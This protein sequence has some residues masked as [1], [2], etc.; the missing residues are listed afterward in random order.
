MS[1]T[2]LIIACQNG[3]NKNT[4]ALALISNPGAQNDRG[5]TALMFAC[6]H[7]MVGTV[8]ALIATGKSN[9]GAKNKYGGT[10]YDY[11]SPELAEKMRKEEAHLRRRYLTIHYDQFH[12][13]GARTGAVPIRDGYG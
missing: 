9:L 4:L 11:A 3:D 2:P 12:P 8:S 5:E 13:Q 10:A 1:D 6:E 7:K